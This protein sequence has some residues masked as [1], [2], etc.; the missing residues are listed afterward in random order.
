LLYKLKQK[1]SENTVIKQY[2]SGGSAGLVN[3]I[4]TP[5]AGI[6]T[7]SLLTRILNAEYFGALQYLKSWILV[8]IP[9]LSLGQQRTLLYKVAGIPEIKYFDKSLYGKGLY[10]KVIFIQIATFITISAIAYSTLNF[11]NYITANHAIHFWLIPISV[12]LLFRSLIESTNLWLQ[13]NQKVFYSQLLSGFTPLLTAFFLS[14][15]YFLSPNPTKVGI[16]IVVAPI[17]T[18][19]LFLIYCNKHIIYFSPRTLT[20]DEF[21]YGL[22]VIGT[23]MV[24]VMNQRID[25]LMLGML[26]GTKPTGPYSIAITLSIFSNLGNDILNPVFTPRLRKFIANYNSNSAK[27]EIDYTRSASFLFG[28]LYLLALLIF[29]DIILFLIGIDSNTEIINVL[30]ILTSAHV[31]THAFGPVG[32]FLSLSGYSGTTL[33]FSVFSVSTAFFAN[34][35]LI[36]SLNMIGAAIGTIT[37]LTTVNLV[38]LIYIYYKWK[39]NLS[40]SMEIFMVLF[41]IL[42]LASYV[43]GWIPEIYFI[44]IISI[45]TL[46]YIGFLKKQFVN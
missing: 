43:I 4:I 36:P 38:M 39:V 25:I 19:F 21:R 24:H 13:S 34:I 5:L 30:L 22:K 3:K 16:A 2:L 31:I 11:T 45:M 42:G 9:L 6:L 10:V 37:A 8:L 32:R 14:I 1:V 29:K 12:L 26:M 17:I 27:K 46:I 18:F 20:K 41:L 7:L 28:L 40:S 23:K 44:I 33:F 35:I 15:I